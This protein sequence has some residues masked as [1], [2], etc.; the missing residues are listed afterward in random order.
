MNIPTPQQ[1]VCIDYPNV[2]RGFSQYDKFLDVSKFL[3][4]LALHS[5]LGLGCERRTCFFLCNPPPSPAGELDKYFFD[6]DRKRKFETFLKAR[7]IDVITRVGKPSHHAKGYEDSVTSK[8]ILKTLRMV[9]RLKPKSILLVS[10]DRDYLPMIDD[11]RDDG[12]F[13]EVAAFEKNIGALRQSAD[14]FIR[15]DDF[16]ESLPSLNSHKGTNDRQVA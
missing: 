8:L 10:G 13:I 16:V 14:N 5:K 9:G 11:L 12:I 3:S 15:I 4:L 1:I 2:L 7:G 6:R